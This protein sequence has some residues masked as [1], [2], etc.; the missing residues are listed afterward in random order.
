MDQLLYRVAKDLFQWINSVAILNEKYSDI[1]KVQ[2][3][4][5]FALSIGP[6]KQG[7]LEK[8]VSYAA[9]QKRESESKYVL[10]MVSYAFPALS[11]LAARMDGVGNRVREEELAL[12]VR[13]YV[14]IEYIMQHVEKLLEAS[15]TLASL[16][17]RFTFFDGSYSL[18]SSS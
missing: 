5:F 4:G 8:F 1:V 2:N 11:V 15:R 13:R 6:L 7:S 10:W 9:Q 18:F 17:S 3:F 12:Y 16:I 14:L